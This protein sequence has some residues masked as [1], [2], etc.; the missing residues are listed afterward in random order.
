MLAGCGS[1]EKLCCKAK[2]LYLDHILCFNKN[3]YFI[4]TI[5]LKLFYRTSLFKSELLYNS[6]LIPGV[7]IPIVFFQN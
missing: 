5:L 3:E 7:S 6:I 4:N 1:C 2:S